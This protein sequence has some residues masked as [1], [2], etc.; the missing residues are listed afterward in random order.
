MN[1]RFELYK[2]DRDQVRWRLGDG[3]RSLAQSSQGYVDKRDAL[4]GI[5]IVRRAQGRYEMFQ[6][7]SQ[8]RWR[9]VTSNGRIVAMSESGFYDRDGCERGIS[10]TREGAASAPVLDHTRMLTSPSPAQ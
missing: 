3:E 2:D 10:E 7:G 6:D 8:W 5:E 9:I 4:R 1:T